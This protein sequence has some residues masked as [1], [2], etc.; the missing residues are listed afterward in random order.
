MSDSHQQ[1]IQEITRL[2]NLWAKANRVGSIPMMREA[3]V[4]GDKFFGYNLNGWAYSGIEEWATLWKFLM[5]SKARV[6]L[7]ED[8][9]LNIIVRGE[10][11]W[12]TCTA[13][14]AITMEDGTAIPG[15]G[16]FRSTEIYVREDESG[17]PNWKMW[18]SH[19]SWAAPKDQPRMG[20]DK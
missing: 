20:F 6:K 2:H 19:F 15:S 18:H 3:F 8:E 4:G 14:F 13:D 5:G 9:D 10:T 7:G 12:L 11:A 16:R 17:N 1:D